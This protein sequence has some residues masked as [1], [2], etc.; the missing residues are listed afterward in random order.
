MSEQLAPSVEERVIAGPGGP[1]RLGI[2]RPAGAGP[3]PILVY[4][5]GGGF[6]GY[7]PIEPLCADIAA[8]TSCVVVAVGYRLAP[9]H[10]FPAAHDDC[11]T[12]LQYCFGNAESFGGLPNWIGVAG[13]S[14]GGTLAAALTLIAPQMDLPPIR[15]QFLAYPLLAG[16]SDTA[17]R[18]EFA[19]NGLSIMVDGWRAY[20]GTSAAEIN[21]LL[22]PLLAKSFQG[23]PP[24]FIVTA[25]RDPLRDEGELYAAR[26]AQAGVPVTL[27]QYPR[28]EHGFLTTR[29]YPEA[30]NAA[31]RQLGEA[32]RQV[33]GA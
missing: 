15:F 20:A 9:A 18:Q 4:F 26:L 27:I 10:T 14:A 13:D 29:T 3:W 8:A 23:L 17:S 6:I 19:E 25:E 12:A 28:A 21:P 33:R 2:Y 11:L 30:R 7:M 24:A 5:I 16:E 1:L 22:E 31:L 32:L